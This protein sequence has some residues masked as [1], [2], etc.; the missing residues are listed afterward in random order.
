MLDYEDWTREGHKIYLEE[1]IKSYSES[2]YI[3]V[4]ARN[5]KAV[6]LYKELGY[7]CLN[8]ITIRKVFHEENFKTIQSENIAGHNFQIRKYIK[9]DL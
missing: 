6:K 9:A 5:L 4:V 7:D 8:T 1:I 3:E 2:L